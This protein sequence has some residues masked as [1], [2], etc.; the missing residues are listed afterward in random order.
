MSEICVASHHRSVHELLQDEEFRGLAGRDGFLVELRLDHYKDLS[1]ESLAQAL[2][3]FAPQAVVTYRHP[4]EGG[5]RANVED[6]ERLRYLQIAADRGVKYIDIEERTPRGNFDKKSARLILSFHDF[7]SVP[8]FDALVQHCK[9]MAADPLADVIKVACF[10]EFIMESVPLLK[11][12]QIMHPKP[13]IV[14]G[15]GEAGFWTRIAGPLF[16]SPLTYARGEAAPGTAPGQPT[17]RELEEVYRFRDLQPKWPVFGVIGNPIA[18]SLSPLLHNTALKALNIDGVYLPFKV[19][20]DPK[21][22]VKAFMPMGLRALSVTIPHKEAVRALCNE[23]HALAESIGAVN[24]L[25]LREDG[26]W[27]TNTDAFAAAD[28]LESVSGSLYGKKVL[29]LGAGGAAKAVAFGIKTRGADVY[30]ANRTV[31]HAVTLAQT[32]GGKVVKY[33]DITAKSEYCAIINTTSVGMH[34]D[35]DNSPLQKDQ[36][37]PLSIVFDTVYNPLRTRLLELAAEQGCRT[38]EGVTM[39]IRQGAAQFELYTDEK[40]PL[41]LIEDTV[42]AELTKRQAAH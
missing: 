36:I 18:H 2:D 28:A 6:A 11:L 22:F 34:P 31:E 5:R 12:L 8:A 32:V 23:V 38:V 42:L 16:G 15:M 4:A 20:G 24:T 39:F 30:I 27:G 3:R 40:P 14:L 21:T 1:D 37:S 10:P 17:W 13:L 33:P 26:W 35:V 19:D 29:I 25:L 9:T 41:K 7:A